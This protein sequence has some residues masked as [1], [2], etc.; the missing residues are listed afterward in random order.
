MLRDILVNEIPGVLRGGLYA[1]PALLG[2]AVVVAAAKAG[3][4]SAAFPLLGML[5][6]FTVRL[7]G[8]RRDLNLPRGRE[9]D[10]DDKLRWS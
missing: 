6:C 10:P 3:S 9:R 1:V 7:T 8:L 4:H 5:V 2:A